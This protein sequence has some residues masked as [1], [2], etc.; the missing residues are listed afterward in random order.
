[1]T[2]KVLDSPRC[3][4]IARAVVSGDHEAFHELVAQL[5]PFL[6]LAL[7]RSRALGSRRTSQDVIRELQ[8]RAIEKLRR[9]EFRTLQ[10][11]F[12]WK[13]LNA[14]KAFEDWLRIVTANLVRSYL[15]GELALA[16]SGG[17]SAPTPNQ[18]FRDFFEAM[19]EREPGVRP[20]V[21]PVQTARQILEFSR[22]HLPRDQSRALELWLE[23]FEFS[24]IGTEIGGA[25]DPN[26]L[27]RRLVRAA[28]AT[29]RRRF[30]GEAA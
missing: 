28:C 1:M 29:L 14:D 18:L 2:G 17:S 22:A 11:Y 7:S 12:A 20:P 30:A 24:E 5:W 13:T 15:R 27:G 26:D 6:G 8:T 16:R 3:E 9:N 4:A 19:G 25:T 10:Q 21:T 23:G